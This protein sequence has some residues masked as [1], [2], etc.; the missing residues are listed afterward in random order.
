[1]AT[2]GIE[3][4]IVNPLSVAGVHHGNDEKA[5]YLCRSV[6]Y[7]LDT[8]KADGLILLSS[9][10]GIYVGDKSMDPLLA[11]MDG[12][13]RRRAALR[14]SLLFRHGDIRVPR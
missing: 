10:N 13:G 2:L 12:R 11:E 14:R 1:M 4:A 3:G 9:Q 8:L 7:A 6:E 5:R